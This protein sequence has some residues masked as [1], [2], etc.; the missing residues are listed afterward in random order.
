MDDNENLKPFLH[1]LSVLRCKLFS[2]THNQTRTTEKYKKFSFS[3]YLNIFHAV[4]FVIAD[5]KRPPEKDKLFNIF[6]LTFFN[7]ENSF[8][9]MLNQIAS[10]F[11]MS[12][13]TKAKKKLEKTLAGFLS[14]IFFR[15]RMSF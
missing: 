11:S 9:I 13:T 12:Q 4:V 6:F 3:L 15:S 8:S 14:Q 5:I 10:E 2:S 7:Y 1:L